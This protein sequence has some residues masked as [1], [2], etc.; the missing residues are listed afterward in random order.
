M[1]TSQAARYREAL[2]SLSDDQRKQVLEAGLGGYFAGALLSSYRIVALEDPGQALSIE[3]RF[4]VPAWARRRGDSLVLRGG[5]YPYQLSASLITSADRSTPLLL[6]DLTN[7]S[8][9]VQISL[10]VGA[11]AELSDGVALEA[12]LSTFRM[13]ASQTGRKLLIDKTLT[14]LPGRVKPSDYPAFRKFCHQVDASDTQGMV[15]ELAKP[16]S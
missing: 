3:Y 8:T 16:G 15:I 1:T 5:F 9:R 14:V 11:R 13:Q 12:P 2:L 7:T 4:R 6:S 10:P